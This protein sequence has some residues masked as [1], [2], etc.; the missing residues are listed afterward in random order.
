LLQAATDN[1]RQ[2]A[3]QAIVRA[4]NQVVH[5]RLDAQPSMPAPLKSVPPPTPPT[6][7]GSTGL[8]D[9]HEMRDIFLEEAREVMQSAREA[10]EQL[11]RDP[12]DLGAMT[13]ARRAFHT[14]K[15]SSRMV[16]LKDFGEAA[17]SCEQLYNVRMADSAPADGD[18][19]D[20]SGEALDYLNRWVDA[21]ASN[22]TAEFKHRIVGRAADALRNERRR[23]PFDDGVPS[24]PGVL[25][26]VDEAPVAAVA[27]PVP[28]AA[29]DIP[30]IEDWAPATLPDAVP[31]PAPSLLVTSFELNLDSDI[32]SSTV[33]T[34]VMPLVDLPNQ[35]QEATQ[36]A[37]PINLI[38]LDLPEVE[39]EPIAPRDVWA[40]P[41]DTQSDA[42]DTMPAALGP[43][44][45]SRRS[46]LEA[47]A[48]VSKLMELSLPEREER[49][50]VAPAAPRMPE[51][52][53]IEALEPIEPEQVMSIGSLSIPIPLFN[54]YLNEAD[55][56]SR[57]LATELAE[58]AHELSRPVGD[59][60]VS[61]AHSLAGNSST[62]GFADLSQLARSLEHALMRSNARGFGIAEEAQL[63]VAAGEEIR[64]LLHQFAAGFLKTADPELLRYLAEHE[65]M[66]VPASSQPEPQADVIEI[67]TEHKSGVES[68]YT[69]L[70]TMTQFTDFG[71]TELRTLAELPDPGH[72]S[73][74]VVAG[75]RADAL[76][77]EDDIDAI[78]A[79]DQELFPIFEEEGQ[80]LIPQLQSRMRDWV[81]R[82]TEASA[83][84]ACM[85]TLHT[86]KGGA[87][88]AG[89]MRLGEMA[90]R[91]ETAIEHLVARG[92]AGAATWSAWSL[93]SM[94]SRCD[95]TCCA[96]AMWIIRSRCHWQRTNL[97]GSRRL[98]CRRR[99]TWRRW[100][101]SRSWQAFRRRSRHPKRQFLS[102]RRSL[103][104][105]RLLSIG[106]DSRDPP[107]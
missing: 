64:R 6:A 76:D 85:R 55:E 81:R 56:L 107:L 7:P 15:G 86:L 21:I 50:D 12:G 82:P 89:A 25:A 65:N 48:V 20:F 9:D 63:F 33:P 78:D 60:V 41:S 17:W 61:F 5:P 36:P 99:A 84:S 104:E 52:P 3:R 88:L 23:I 87:R 43:Y 58:W 106:V 39:P 29:P 18:L 92:H 2:Q 45:D 100:P 46:P 80:E 42:L 96:V 59:S 14:L 24:G 90:H 32:P 66:A 57:R 77:D 1:E 75:V 19:L 67:E 31:A 95:S 101:R 72:R 54:I 35:V 83:A 8:E 73:T 11:A 40:A 71:H 53:A 94:R 49:T 62:V 98:P 70:G 68:G 34:E 38:A 28:A 26:A 10:L 4:M 30:P 13:S 105:W 37:E 74:V 91:L 16:G 47:P 69:P 97:S 44:V 27:T 103:K 93:G 22:H 79:I 51:P 102:H